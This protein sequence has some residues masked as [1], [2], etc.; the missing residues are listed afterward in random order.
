MQSG[1]NDPRLPHFWDVLQSLS[2]HPLPWTHFTFFC[3]PPQIFAL[4]KSCLGHKVILSKA[5]KWSWAPN[6]ELLVGV[7]EL[8]D[9]VRLPISLPAVCERECHVD[10]YQTCPSPNTGCFS[11]SFLGHRATCSRRNREKEKRKLLGIIIPR[12]PFSFCNV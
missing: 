2:R 1:P 9:V 5:S 6:N 12:V 10:S 3:H 8:K 4:Q 11:S 7:T